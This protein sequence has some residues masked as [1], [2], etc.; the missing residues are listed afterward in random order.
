MKFASTYCF[1]MMIICAMSSFSNNIAEAEVLRDV[2]KIKISDPECCVQWC[3]SP[4]RY[5]CELVYE[6][7]KLFIIHLHIFYYCD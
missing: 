7:F 1:M 6:Y 3:T 4:I 2:D 5:C